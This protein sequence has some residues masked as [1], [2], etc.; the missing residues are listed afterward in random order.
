MYNDEENYS[1]QTN[2]EENRDNREMNAGEEAV[3][4]NFT[5]RDPDPDLTE[6][7]NPVV[8]SAVNHTQQTGQSDTQSA[9]GVRLSEPVCFKS[10]TA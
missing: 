6:A 8:S 5:M 3:T 7:V 1:G 4:P 10:G 2:P 9:A